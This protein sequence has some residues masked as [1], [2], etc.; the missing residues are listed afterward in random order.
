MDGFPPATFKQR[1]ERIFERLGRGA[2]VLPAA[3]VR[4][5]SRDTEYPYRP[6]SDLF[7]ATGVVEPEAV[8][9]L[10]GHAEEDGAER[11]VLFVRPRDEE[12]ELWTGRRMGPEG[13]A[14]TYGVDATYPVD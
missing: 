10:R 1:R 5:R 13:A 14:T 4:Y 2:M 7:W 8:A 11:F 6:D 3:P 12:A 9:V